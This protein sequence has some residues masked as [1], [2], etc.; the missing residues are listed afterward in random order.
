MF[1]DPHT[2]LLVVYAVALALILNPLLLVVD[3]HR[4]QPQRLARPLL[5]LRV[6]TGEVLELICVLIVHGHAGLERVAV[7]VVNVLSPLVIL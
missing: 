3:P 4:P 2:S 6:V 5:D 1:F 7:V